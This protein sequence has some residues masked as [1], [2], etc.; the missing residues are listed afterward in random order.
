M[1]EIDA[2][3]A[4]E[5]YDA[6]VILNFVSNPSEDRIQIVRASLKRSGKKDLELYTAY[7]SVFEVYLDTAT[8]SREEAWS[9]LAFL[10]EHS[11]HDPN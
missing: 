3:V 4:S 9:K 11:I 1:S 8:R 6:E 7:D 2:I 5:A 10:I